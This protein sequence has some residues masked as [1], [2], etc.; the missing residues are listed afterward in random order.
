M[1]LMKSF[2]S[3]LVMQTNVLDG[4]NMKKVDF[5]KLGSLCTKMLGIDTKEVLKY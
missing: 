1:P 2:D 5:I 4:I 3:S